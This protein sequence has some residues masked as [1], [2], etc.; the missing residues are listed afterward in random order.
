MIHKF[1]FP[2]L[3]ISSNIKVSSTGKY[4][5]IYVNSDLH[6]RNNITKITTLFQN[7]GSEGVY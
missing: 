6:L 2:G 7:F 5:A 1:N 3:G 4:T